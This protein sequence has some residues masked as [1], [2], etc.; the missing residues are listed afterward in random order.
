[1]RQR[2]RRARVRAALRA[3][4]ERLDALRLRADELACLDN[5]LL[6]AALCPSRRNA[7]VT[8]RE[9][10]AEGRFFFAVPRPAAD[11]RFAA[12]RVFVDVVPFFGG[13]SFTPARRAFESPIAMACLAER[14]PCLPART[15]SIS[16]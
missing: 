2:R 16:S 15:C 4:A 9:R 13:G 8:A 3:A 10:F 6:D 1:M 12:W 7:L 14:A 5:A 11:A